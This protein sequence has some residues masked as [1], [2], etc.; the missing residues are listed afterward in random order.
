MARLVDS[1]Y[2]SERLGTALCFGLAL[3]ILSVGIYLVKTRIGFSNGLGWALLL[4]SVL[5]LVASGTYFIGLGD[6]HAKYAKLLA[7]DAPQFFAQETD[8]MMQAVRSFR[9]VILGE[10]SIALAAIGL[11]ILGQVRGTQGL[12]GIGVGIA[13]VAL[14]LAFYDSLNRERAILYRQTL[15]AAL[16]PGTGSPPID[17]QE[18]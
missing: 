18:H 12:S 13:L 3:V 6:N 7:T 1:Y 10:I 5:I 16:T 4:G 8:H 15:Q 9:W 2:T 17:H 14:V 11:I